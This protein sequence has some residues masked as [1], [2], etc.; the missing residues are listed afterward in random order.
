MS[1]GS[2]CFR[3]GK[4]TDNKKQVVVARSLTLESSQAKL[5]MCD[6][7]F[8]ERPLEEDEERTCEVLKEG[9]LQV[10]STGDGRRRFVKLLL[11]R[12]RVGGSKSTL[13]SENTAEAI[14]RGLFADD[15][16]PA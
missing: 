13:S 15:P 4:R 7:T 9:S 6:L 16:L 1:V 11:A 8:P 3:A 12:E 2:I 10:E 14:S 5:S